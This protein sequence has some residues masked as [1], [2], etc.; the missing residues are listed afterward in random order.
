MGSET[1]EL[2]TASMLTGVTQSSLRGLNDI[3]KHER[4]LD[5]DFGTCSSMVIKDQ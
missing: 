4:M 2:L 3:H 5:K 1:C